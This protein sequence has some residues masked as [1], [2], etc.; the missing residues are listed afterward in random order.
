MKNQF[1]KAEDIYNLYFPSD[2]QISPNGNKLLYV[3]KWINKGDNKYY[4]NIRSVEISNKKEKPLTKG[5]HVDFSPRWHPLK[6]QIIFIRKKDNITSL[7]S[8]SLKTKKE[9]ELAVFK[10]GEVKKITFSPNGEYI[11]LLL[12]K[13]SKEIKLDKNNKRKTPVVRDIDRLYYR[14][15]GEGFSDSQKTQLYIIKG[16]NNKLQKVTKAKEDISN[17]TWSDYSD[18]I[19]Y[20]YNANS[21]PDR[22]MEESEIFIYDLKKRKKEKL[23]KKKG[24]VGFLKFSPDNKFLYFSGHFKPN[25]SWGVENMRIHR[26][27]LQNGKI[28]SMTKKIDRTTEMLTLGD[29]S[30]MFT[31]QEPIIDPQME[32]MYFTISSNGGNPLLKLS[33]KT[34]KVS[35][36]IDGKH[37]IVSYSA[38]NNADSFAIHLTQMKHPDEIYHLNIKEKSFEK[39]T[40]INEKYT[41]KRIYNIPSSSIVKNGSTSIHTWLLKPP[42]FDPEKKY[43]L[44]LNIHGGP[45]CQYGYNW[46]HE[47]HFFAA[48]GYVVLYTNPRGSQGYGKKFADAITGKWAEPAYS[49][50][51]K[52][53]K[54]FS[55]QKYIDKNN[56]FV[57]GGSYGGYMTNWIVTQTN[58][59]KAAVT[60][61][62]ISNLSSFFGTS[63]FGWD[64]ATEFNGPPWKK[65]KTYK[66]WSAL[67]YAKRIKTP[68]MII[69]SENDLRC[70]ME[71]AEQL[72]VRLKYDKKDVR[73]IRFPEEP[74]G[75][76]RNGKP[77]RRVKRLELMLEWFEKYRRQ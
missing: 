39:I 16:Q 47:M 75:L 12:H 20:T 43:P 21:D 76:S 19:A 29:I 70:P 56:L 5:N 36:V 28:K 9:K 2:P 54:I 58:C 69:H 3:K 23:K 67:T 44:L 25:H 59:F 31:M 6:E 10:R 65:K 14:E 30:P 51:M 60:Q 17:F 38:S 71:Q 42:N 26:I 4:S 33:L 46:F 22:Y 7:I 13:F 37:S 40:S 50:L 68:L 11:G 55:K 45:R 73:L 61:R 64:L 41:N 27:S 49:D 48:N 35:Y 34:D 74:H 8:T 62:S 32:N 1:I 18:K 63:D 66:K 24:P 77:D 57:T 72:F 52:C 53:V 15:D